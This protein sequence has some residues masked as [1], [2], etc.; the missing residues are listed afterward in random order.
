M[1]VYGYMGVHMYMYISI[2]MHTYICDERST[3]TERGRIGRGGTE[4]EHTYDSPAQDGARFL[5]TISDMSADA[6]ISFCADSA[7]PCAL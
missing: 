1:C 5:S 6:S 2:Y 7:A 3:S 4:G